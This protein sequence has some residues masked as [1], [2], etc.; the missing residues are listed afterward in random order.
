MCTA[1]TAKCVSGCSGD[2]LVGFIYGQK[3]KKTFAIACSSV[4]PEV[5]DLNQPQSSKPTNQN[6]RFVCTF[7]YC[8]TFRSVGLA[9]NSKLLH[10]TEL[11][12]SK[13]C[14]L[15]CFKNVNESEKLELFEFHRIKSF[16]ALSSTHV[17]LVRLHSKHLLLFMFICIPRAEFI[18]CEQPLASNLCV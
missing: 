17:P 14:F 9:I 16:S 7:I 4:N 15:F 8:R 6:V 10:L 5:L 12:G 2:E 3:Q 13:C 1:S 18:H 11:H